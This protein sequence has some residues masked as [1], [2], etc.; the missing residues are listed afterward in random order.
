LLKKRLLLHTC[1]APCCAYVYQLLK[2]EYDVTLFFYNPNILPPAEYSKRRDELRKFVALHT[3]SLVEGEYSYREWVQ[4]IYPYRLQGER[5]ARCWL[6][7]RIRME[8]TF[9]YA[10]KQGFDLA[11]TVLSISPHKSVEKIHEIGHELAGTYNI[12]YLVADFKKQDGFKKSVALSRS[13]N[14]YRQNYCGCIYSLKERDKE[15]VWFKRNK[16]EK[17]FS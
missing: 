9:S 15:S 10:A 14:F 17:I 6:C 8:K 3:I 11:G 1:C 13:Y 2:N 5:S 4:Q 7:Y 16:R 12:P